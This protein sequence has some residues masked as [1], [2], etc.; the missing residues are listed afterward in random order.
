MTK[1]TA[2]WDV[3][4]SGT[5]KIFWHDNK[6][7]ETSLIDELSFDEFGYNTNERV[8]SD[9]ITVEHKNDGTLSGW[10]R[11]EWVRE[12][13][14][15][16]YAPESDW[17]DTDW[18]DLT[19]IP[20]ASVPSIKTY[21]N[22]TPDFNLGDTI[23]IHMNRKSSSFTHKVWIVY[24]GSEHLIAQNVANSCTL[25]TSTVE[26]DITAL[27]PTAN[28]YNGTIKVTTYNGNTIIGTKTCPYKAHV[29]DANP[30]FSDFSYEDTNSATTAITN[31]NQLLIQGKS[32][33]SAYVPV[34]D[35][36]VAKKNAS[37]IQ[38]LASCASASATAQWSDSST[39]IMS[40]GTIDST[41]SQNLAVGAKDS[42]AN[43]TVVNK[44][45]T[46]IPYSSPVLYITGTRTNNFENNTKISFQANSGI[47]PIQVSGTRKNNVVELSYRYKKATDANFPASFTPI[48]Y[49]LGNDGKITVSDFYLTLDNA[50][51]W[52]L[53]FKIE[54][55]LETQY[56]TVNVD[57]GIAIFRIGEDGKVYVQENEVIHKGN[58]LDIFYPVGSY[59]ETSDA[60]F[61]PNTAWGG[62]WVEDSRGKFLVGRDGGSDGIF[63]TVGET[64]G[65]VR[66]TH[67]LSEDGYALLVLKGNG[68]IHYREKSVSQWT[69]NYYAG[70]LDTRG[71]SSDNQ[72]YAT[73]LGG[74]TDSAI[75][76]PPY[77]TVVRWHRTA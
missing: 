32:I 57:V 24:G 23:T 77:L 16:G 55:S 22:N 25:D 15:G 30:E 50:F 69:D 39:A 21:P 40:L 65:N 5:L 54:D 68:S 66:H 12:N 60:D 58:W 56:F 42:R 61:N 9:T 6:T 14:Y 72:T 43:I 53:Q 75:G 17:V 73:V 19:T 26:N 18:K 29:V 28:V 49:T 7:G 37:M 31:N 59:Y 36:A 4:D 71:S 3:T 47:S 46:V 34:A 8:A 76:L 1:N 2:S 33:L 10:A 74:K 52:D 62:T 51:Q 48:S 45:L 11:A 44:T 35:K 63:D 13:S 64:G 70:Y 41:G 67:N 20:R 38:Y 27:I